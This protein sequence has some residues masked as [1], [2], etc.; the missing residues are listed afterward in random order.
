MPCPPLNDFH[1]FAN[2]HIT[3]CANRRGRASQKEISV[4][5]HQP[6]IQS[7][8]CVGCVVWGRFGCTVL[9]VLPHLHSAKSIRGRNKFSILFVFLF[10]CLF[11]FLPFC[12]FAFSYFPQNK[13]ERI[14]GKQKRQAIGAQRT[15]PW[16]T[17]VV[18][19]TSFCRPL[20]HVEATRDICAVHRHRAQR[21]LLVTFRRLK[22]NTP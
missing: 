16:S 6:T 15:F 3:W 21:R 4:F 11:A 1:V 2:V 17:F 5:S 7:R 18:Y 22:S 8:P 12:F 14:W 13:S 19:V 20:S 10:F 9:C